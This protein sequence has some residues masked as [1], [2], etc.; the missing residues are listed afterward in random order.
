[1]NATANITGAQVSFLDLKR[2]HREV[3][4]EISESLARVFSRG[5]FILG[6]EVAAFE[7]EW[8]HFCRARAA[9][10]TG[11]GTDA[12]TLAL[13]ASGAVRQGR[14]D[15]VI[16]APL[17]AAYT[18]LAILRAGGVPVFADIDP[19]TYT[20]DPSAVAAAITPRTR[21]IV[22]VH[23]Y[24]Q[25]AAMKPLSA[26]A[27]AHD[28]LM[29]EDAAQAHG[30][31]SDDDWPGAHSLAAIWSFYP[32]KNLGAFGDGGAVTSNDTALIERI[33][34]LRQG[35]HARA[36]A[37][38]VAGLNSRLD[39]LQAAMLRVRLRRLT[40]WNARRRALANYYL[41]SF[42]RLPLQLPTEAAHAWHLFVIQHERREELRAHL[43]ARGV[44]TLIHYPYLLH[45]QPLFRRGEQRA[46]PVAEA[47][48]RRI[49]SL[50]L[51]PQLAPD[52]ARQVVS[53]IRE[54]AH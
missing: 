26:I 27:A 38:K 8:A 17:T 47:T 41:E 43:A 7:T 1:M 40:E 32:T 33:R 22:P 34:L 37:E 16:T 30:A 5:V 54:F 53:A 46:L 24:G 42:K 28:L 23:L 20:L 52:E 10:A 13:I 50:P 2:A 18:A 49:L 51:Y 35:G 9:A 14:G 36:I 39:E 3:E 44:E 15:E 45:E 12:L 25:M 48:V 6:P 31:G 11:N 29:I 21:A 4:A 19:Q